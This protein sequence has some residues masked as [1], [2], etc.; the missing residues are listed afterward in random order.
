MISV[1]ERRSRRQHARVAVAVEHVRKLAVALLD[2][3]FEL[4]S[5]YAGRVK[6]LRRVF[7]GKPGVGVV[8]ARLKIH[9]R[10]ALLGPSVDRDMRFGQNYRSGDALGLETMKSA[11]HN[12]SVSGLRGGNHHSRNASDI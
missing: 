3:A 11:L 12:G 8:A 6:R 10:V 7:A 2:S 1:I 4:G 9:R 5:E